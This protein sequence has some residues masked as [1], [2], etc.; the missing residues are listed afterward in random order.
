MEQ[1]WYM[2]QAVEAE[3]SAFTAEFERAVLHA[4]VR[5]G[6]LCAQQCVECEKQ[7]MQEKLKR[8]NH[9]QKKTEKLGGEKP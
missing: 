4:L 5:R 9:L 7:L 8:E 2:Q 6:I 3:E 1:E